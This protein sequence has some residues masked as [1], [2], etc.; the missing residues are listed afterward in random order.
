MSG[1]VKQLAIIAVSGF[2]V[3]QHIAAIA[4][5]NILWINIDDQSPWY[6]SYE[7]TKAQTPNIDALAREGVAFERAYASSPACGPS[8]SAIITGSYSIRT[9]THDMR[10][11][12]DS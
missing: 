12:A 6:G 8:R 2:C 1:L 5:T 10:S 7:K 3:L 9:G 4:K 11:G